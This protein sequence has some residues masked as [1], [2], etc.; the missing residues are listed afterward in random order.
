VHFELHENDSRRE[1]W[2]IVP[3]WDLITSEFVSNDPWRGNLASPSEYTFF[4]HG[5]R[6]RDQ[7]SDAQAPHRRSAKHRHLMPAAGASYSAPPAMADPAASYRTV[8]TSPPPV[9][10]PYKP[11]EALADLPG[12]AY[13]LDQFLASKMHESEDYCNQSDPKKCVSSRLCAAEDGGGSFLWEGTAVLC[14]RV[15]PH[16]VRQGADVLRGRGAWWAHS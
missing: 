2:Q 6:P 5:A 4:N 14:D 13:A 9:K 16:P 7:S 1:D 12:V 3:G 11:T 10:M 8:Y 15:R